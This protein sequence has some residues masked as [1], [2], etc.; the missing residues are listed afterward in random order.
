MRK[1]TK[2]RTV[3]QIRKLRRVQQLRLD[4]IT[5]D[6]AR[7]TRWMASIKTEPAKPGEALRLE[8]GGL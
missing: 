7:D 6:A 5:F 3:K 8:R 1:D 4:I 2:M